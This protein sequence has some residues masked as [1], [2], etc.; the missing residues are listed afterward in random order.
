MS[1]AKRKEALEKILKDNK[2]IKNV[3]ICYSLKGMDKGMFVAQQ[4]SGEFIMD[5]LLMIENKFPEFLE[6]FIMSRLV[7]VVVEDATSIAANI[8][9]SF[10]AELVKKSKGH[11][12][13]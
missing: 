4:C 8:K 13:G 9:D 12:D 6:S 10:E 1:E 2:E 5:I 3:F 11:L 7:E